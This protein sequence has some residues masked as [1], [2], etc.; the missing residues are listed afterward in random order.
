MKHVPLPLTDDIRL[1]N[2]TLDLYEVWM[3]DHIGAKG[4]EWAWCMIVPGINFAN[5]SDATAFVL[6]FN[7]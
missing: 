3:N 6:K 1:N 4:T 2:E 7:V 5:D